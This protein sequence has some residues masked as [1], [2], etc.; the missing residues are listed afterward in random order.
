MLSHTWRRRKWAQ[1]TVALALAG[2]LYPIPV[3]ILRDYYY[4]YHAWTA[5]SLSTLYIWT[6]V[7]P[8][9]SLG[10]FALFLKQAREREP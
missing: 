5:H 9:A 10:M 3:D 4:R 2:L 8:F 1:L 6:S 7:T